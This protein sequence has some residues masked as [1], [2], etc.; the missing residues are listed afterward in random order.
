MSLCVLL[1]TVSAPQSQS[2]APPPRSNIGSCPPITASSLGSNTTLSTMGL[3]AATIDQAN[4][5][6][7]VS[8]VRILD[9]QLVCEAAG[10]RRDTISSF[11]VVARYECQG[12]FCDSA[13]PG[14]PGS[15][16]R[17]LSLDCNQDDTFTMTSVQ[18]G[19]EL[20]SP[21]VENPLSISL[22][23]RC[24]ECTQLAR[25]PNYCAGMST[26]IS[27]LCLYYSYAISSMQCFM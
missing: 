1:L 2:Q 3:V 18:R 13:V 9:S 20:T 24:G 26:M 19:A 15:F 22:N 10:L 27:P 4:S 17:Y 7:D 23:N 25:N 16:T 21:T 11:S 14:T 8:L 6:S 5:A 12:I